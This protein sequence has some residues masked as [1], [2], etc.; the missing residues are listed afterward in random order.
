MTVPVRQMVL[1]C[2]CDMVADISGVL[3]LVSVGKEGSSMASSGQV[4]EVVM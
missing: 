1:N 4:P 3:L 2:I